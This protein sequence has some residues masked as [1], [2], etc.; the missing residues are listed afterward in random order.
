VYLVISLVR[1]VVRYVF[2]PFL[3]SLFIYFCMS[4]GRLFYIALVI[5]VFRSFY[6]PFFLSACS[7]LFIS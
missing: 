5:S 7:Y 6:I 4:F 2:I 3:I 1:Y